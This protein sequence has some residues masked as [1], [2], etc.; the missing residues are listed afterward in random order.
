MRDIGPTTLVKPAR[1]AHCVAVGSAPNAVQSSIPTLRTQASWLVCLSLPFWLGCAA[2]RP[3]DGIPAR[4]TPDELKAPS[5][6]GKKT[7]DL[8]LLSQPA[9]ANNEYRVDGGDVLGVYIESVL[10]KRE[11]PPP[12]YFPPN[13]DAPPSLGYPIPVRPDGTISLPLLSEPMLV[14][15]L[16][17]AEVERRVIHAYTVEKRHLNPSNARILV[18][19]QQPRKYRVLVLRQE[20]GAG[21][22]GGGGGFNAGMLKTGTGETVSLP[23]YENDVLHA[24]TNSTNG[25]LPSLDAENAIYIVRRKVAPQSTP[26]LS[27]TPISNIA[28]P[29]LTLPPA[30][31]D[32]EQSAYF[33]P[34]PSTRS[35]PTASPIPFGHSA[36]QP[37]PTS[38]GSS[39]ITNL[40]VP[41]PGP[42]I[43]GG[44]APQ[45]N[46][47]VATLPSSF[48]MHLLHRNGSTIDNPHVIKIPIRLGADERPQF[49]PEDV[50]LQNGDIV[51]IESRDTEIFYT[52]GLLGGGQFTLPRDYDIDV[53]HAISIAQGRTVGAGGGGSGISGGLGG[54]SALNQDVTISASSVVVLRQL[55][56]GTQVPIKVDLYKAMRDPK[57][58]IVI[59]PGDYVVLQYKPGEAVAAFFERHFL[60]SAIF[61]IAASGLNN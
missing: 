33:Q 54:F 37:A 14:R 53:L 1:T 17:I 2:F 15:G 61:G 60:Q 23:A 56:N 26:V 4:F 55:S 11:E 12:V 42:I 50:I 32:I 44:V 35:T 59:K 6:T 48:P 29:R 34:E 7:I 27:P 52:G 38:M 46:W 22:G 57:E 39:Q 3:L 40:G 8:S 25:G 45:H 20:S 18:S 36:L 28:P 47:N 5:R 43:N 19:L 31:R 41:D 49:A 16:T 10:G 58:R 9:P 24:L 30:P 13:E 51:F 21:A